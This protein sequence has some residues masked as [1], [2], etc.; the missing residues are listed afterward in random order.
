MI[1]CFSFVGYSVAE[2]RIGLRATQ[3]DVN[4]AAEYI[5]TN[6]QKRKESRKKTLDEWSKNKEKYKLG[7][8]ADGKQYVE[9][10]FLDMLVNMGY[11]KETARRALQQSNNNVS[12]SVQI[13]QEN[14]DLLNLPNTTSNHSMS[15]VIED[16]IPRVSDDA[17]R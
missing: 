15:H 2:A 17:F 10:R 8:C 12:L 7:K 4:A 11:S 9:P 13:I 1:N 16:M 14:P 3:G 5:N 6:R